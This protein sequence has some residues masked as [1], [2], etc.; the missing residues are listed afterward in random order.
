MRDTRQERFY[1]FCS[2]DPIEDVESLF[3]KGGSGDLEVPAKDLPPFV[4]VKGFCTTQAVDADGEEVVPEGLDFG[5]FMRSGRLTDGHPKRRDN[6]VGEPIE[7]TARRHPEGGN[8]YFLKGKLYLHIPRGRKILEDHTRLLKSGARSG[9]GFSIEGKVIQRDPRN[10]KRILKGV[11]DS[12][13]IDPYP[14]NHFSLL[15]A[16]QMAMGDSGMTVDLDPEIFGEALEEA[17]YK[18]LSRH[19]KEADL[20]DRFNRDQLMALAYMVKVPE[21]SLSTAMAHVRRFNRGE[22]IHAH[23]AG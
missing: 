7:L 4:I 6:I 11:I 2:I 20:V 5:P 13:A 21:M 15:E 10:R 19:R 14:K 3:V 1:Q 12:V 9:L 22:R 23:Q 18:A 17:F 8:G 16:I